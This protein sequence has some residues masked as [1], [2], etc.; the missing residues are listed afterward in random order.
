MEGKALIYTPEGYIVEIEG[1]EL[2]PIGF[3]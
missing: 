1:A 3:N 2:V